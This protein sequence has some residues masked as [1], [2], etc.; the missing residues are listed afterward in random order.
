MTTHIGNLDEIPLEVQ[1][2]Q[3]RVRAAG[4][5]L[6]R[7]L[8]LLSTSQPRDL[9]ITMLVELFGALRQRDLCDLL[10]QPRSTISRVVTGLTESNR[11][12]AYS[13]QDSATGRPTAWLMLPTHELPNAERRRSIAALVNDVVLVRSIPSPDDAA[14]ADQP[15][16]QSTVSRSA[17]FSGAVT[18]ARTSTASEI[19][20]SHPE[21]AP[22][23]QP[24]FREPTNRPD[25][26]LTP[27]P[28]LPT[29]THPQ[30][31]SL[32]GR[33]VATGRAIQLLWRQR[34][35]HSAFRS[36]GITLPRQR[37][38]RLGWWLAVTLL[39]L[40]I[41]GGIRLPLLRA[42]L[43][44]TMHTWFTAVQTQPTS[45]APPP[46]PSAMPTISVFQQARVRGTGA[47]GLAVRD[48]PGGQRIGRLAEGSLVTI[49][50]EPRTIVDTS[51]AVWWEVETMGVHGWVSGRYL[52]LQVD[53]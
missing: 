3:E 24:P 21:E 51:N 16:P 10:S 1:A 49:L 4:I 32:L 25:I 47:T 27:R 40:V 23:P 45:P 38:R 9:A 8:V 31:R 44:S 18:A 33:L 19:V 50:S 26:D 36:A 5:D 15:E 35:T 41:L 52:D 14:M 11:L 7:L 22:S 17:D 2:A 12:R 13:L 20:H 48:R 6:E 53:H 37:R 34:R 30:W 28:V 29:T 42:M 46:Q 39:M 43:L